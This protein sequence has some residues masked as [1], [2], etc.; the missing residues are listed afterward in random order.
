MKRT[1]LLSVTS[2]CYSF[3]STPN[4]TPILG[5]PPTAT[6]PYDNR[7]SVISETTSYFS[8]PSSPSVTS[9]NATLYQ[10]NQQIAT[11]PSETSLENMHNER[12][13][14]NNQAQS[15]HTLIFED[16]I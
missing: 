6:A 13:F 12:I 9:F 1:S 8:I 15:E 4:I 14:E 10:E 2:S 3:S 5:E 16:E 7:L 11:A